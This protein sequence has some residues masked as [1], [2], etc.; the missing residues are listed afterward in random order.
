MQPKITAIS[1]KLGKRDNLAL[2]ES[3]DLDFIPYA[4]HYDEETIL[5]KQGELLKI[6]KLEDYSS[7]DNYSDLRTEIRKSI[8]KN[9]NSLYFT[10]WIH[11]VRKRNKLTLKWNKTGDFSDELHSTRLNKLTDSKL[12]YINELYIVVVFSDFGK[13]SNNSFFL[14]R[15]ENEYKLF[16]QENHQELKKVTDLIQSDLEP[17]GAKKLGL[18]FS[19]GEVYSEMTEFLHYIVTLTRKDY[20]IRE[21]DLSQHVKDLKVAFG[22]NTFQT[23]FENQQKFGSIFCIKEYREIPLENI[24]RCLQLDSELIITEIIIFTSNNKAVKEFKNQINMLQISEDSNLFRS[25]GI[26]EIMELENTSAID[27]CQQKI[28]ITIF[29]DDR[30]KLAKSISDLSSTMSL[31]GLMMF[32]TDLHMEN[33]FWAQLPGNFAFVTQPKNILAKYACSFAMLHDFTSG[34][35]KGGRWKEAVTVFFSKKGSPYFF[36][37]H[38]K[39][40][41]GHT[42]ILGAPNSGRTSLINFL[43]SESRK[44]NPRIVIL[45]NTGKSIIFT[46]AVSG[47]YYIIDP[48]YKDKSLKFNPLNI[49]DSASSRNM[50]VELIKRMVDDVSLVDVEEKIKKIVDSIFTIP[51]ESRSISQI[52]E[53]LLLLGGKISRWCDDG[54]FAY[55]FQDSDE[56]DIDWETKIISLNTANLTKRKECMSVILYYFLYSFEAKCDGSPAILVLDE[57]WEISSIFS[58]EEEFDNWMQ[59]MTKLNVVVILSTENLNLAFASKFTQY[60]DKHVDTRILMPN[61]NANRLYMKAF[62][63][64]KEELNTILQTPT[65]EGLFLIKQYKG[66]V[67]L[68]LDL[69]DMQEIHVL[70]A[71]KETIKYM[72]EAI[73]EKGEKVNK[74][75]PVFYEKCRA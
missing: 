19:E 64:S 42:T 43:L 11:T 10:V 12:Q 36:N 1:S 56:S 70:S 34:T 63:L 61:V 62:S 60:L 37:F 40:N 55:L 24:D 59:R 58:T 20:P 25:S 16:L 13:H 48:K 6:I 66:L 41:N 14:S 30:T 7:A 46:K 26:K 21:M 23:T 54:E 22:F 50:L 8:S 39:K 65:Q 3:I 32:R 5:T 45:D 68:N 38:G 17:C 18:R 27:F 73:K 31:I 15:I 49:E 4:C 57:A 67:T 2:L 44:F 69:R 53:V 35:L 71:N 74:W 9:I 29:A 72:Y 47:E 52:S 75:L 33:H 51:R 28:I